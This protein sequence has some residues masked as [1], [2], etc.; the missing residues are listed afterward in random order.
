VSARVGPDGS[1]HGTVE[2]VCDALGL[3]PD[4]GSIDFAV[5]CAKGR[6]RDAVEDMRRARSDLGNARVKPAGKV[7]ADLD[8]AIDLAARVV[9]QLPRGR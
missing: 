7:L 5:L 8:V 1:V 9:G 4:D 2:E 3:P 6:L